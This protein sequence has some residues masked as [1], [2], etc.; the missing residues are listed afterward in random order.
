MSENIMHAII[1]ILLTLIGLWAVGRCG[2]MSIRT[3]LGDVA[4][5]VSAAI[6]AFGMAAYNA[7]H[8]MPPVELLLMFFGGLAWWLLAEPLHRK[9]DHYA[10]PHAHGRK[11]GKH[12]P[13]AH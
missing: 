1:S 11:R 6:G 10:A 3:R 5:L 13:T 9:F 12:A 4:A 7:L 2:P 8:L